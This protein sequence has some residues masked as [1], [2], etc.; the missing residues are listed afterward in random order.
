MY[1]LIKCFVECKEELNAIGIYPN[2]TE[3]KVKATK[4]SRSW[5]KCKWNSRDGFRITI[6]TKLLDEST[7]YRSLRQTMLHELLHAC[8]ECLSCSHD[9]KWLEYANMVNDCYGLNIKRSNSAEELNCMIEDKKVYV[10]TCERCGNIN[11]Y[12]RYRA[13]RVYAHLSNYRC[14][15]CHGKL[16]QKGVYTMNEWKRIQNTMT[17]A[18]RV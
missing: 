11:H 9:G 5:G 15:I 6:S 13:P 4:Q 2:I 8:D 17:T 7:P 10:I 1:N 14:G 16:A 18:V 3:Q 12:V